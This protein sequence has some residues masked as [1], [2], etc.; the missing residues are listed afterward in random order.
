MVQDYGLFEQFL[1]IQT[2]IRFRLKKVI[3][4]SLQAKFGSIYKDIRDSPLSAK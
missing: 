3:M 1:H 2:L 4:Q